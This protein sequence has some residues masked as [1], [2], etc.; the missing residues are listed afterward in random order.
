MPN[1]W[2]GATPVE[3]VDAGDYELGTA[4]RAVVDVT[5]THARVWT[6]AGEVSIAG[7]KARVWSAVG[8][9]LGI[10]TLPDNLPTGWSEHEYDTPVEVTAGTNV[11]ASYSSGGNYGIVTAAFNTNVSSADGNI[12][13]LGFTNF[14]N[15]N[16]LFNATPGSYPATGS[17]GHHFY[18]SDVVYSVGIGGNTAPE[19]TALTANA[20]G[21]VVTATVAYTDAEDLIAATT[22]FGWGDGTPDTV[23]TYPTMT[24]QHTYTGSGLYAVLAT[25]TDSL[26]ASATAATPVLVTV[27]DAEV[28]ELD[29]L[30]LL[31]ALVTHAGGLGLFDRVN[32]A[33]FK[34][35]PGHGLSATVWAKSLEPV[36]SSG[37]NASSGRLVVF[38]RIWSG[39]QPGTDEEIDPEIVRAAD[40]L[41]AAY[42]GDFTLGGLVREVDVHGEHGVML[43]ADFGY[44]PLD[45]HPYRVA[46]LTVP[47]I[48]NDLWEQVA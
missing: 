12:T 23:V 16:G 36:A 19:I 46:L 6:G 48:I 27:P 21:A 11:V 20:D 31:N 45:D 15:G 39:L 4:L 18:G 1:A 43:S 8:V 10:A 44:R 14:T 13:L 47:L 26:A 2:S 25:V 17:G 28:G 40:R 37:L 7:R 35:A 32:T 33:D 5:L 41:I 9:Q 38:I 30:A 34:S 22:R 24:A 3:Q 42:I 29:T